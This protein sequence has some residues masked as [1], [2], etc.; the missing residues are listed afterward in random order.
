MRPPVR[1]CGAV[2]VLKPEHIAAVRKL[3]SKA[4]PFTGPVAAVAV[5]ERGEHRVGDGSEWHECAL[6]PL[7]WR[8][9]GTAVGIRWQ[10]HRV[11]AVLMT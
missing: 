3:P 9:G 2:A 5:C 6:R 11:Q 4:P 10:G 1:P 7:D 8:Y